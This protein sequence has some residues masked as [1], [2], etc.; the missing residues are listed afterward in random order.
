[1]A[2]LRSVV[3]WLLRL[4][5]EATLLVTTVLGG[6]LTL[7][8]AA[9]GAGVYDAVAERDG[10]AHL[11]HPVLAQMMT[12]R[13]PDTDRLL[14]VF[15][16]LGG[17]LAMT[18]IATAITA[19][20]CWRWRSWTPLIL[21]AVTVAGSLTFT[22]VG[23]AIVGRARPPLIDAV[24]PY[25]HSFS[26]PSGH[27]LNSTAIAGIVTYLVIRRLRRTVVRVLCV[28]AG[29]A[30]AAAIG[31]SR[32]FLGHHW[33]TDVLFAWLLGMAWITILITAHRVYLALHGTDRRRGVPVPAGGPDDARSARR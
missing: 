28:A 30:W 6:V 5:A 22:T 2:E 3:R 31:F 12:W 9:G 21:M 15:T 10:V 32:V 4:P 33:F 19:L 8:L 27:T 29:M 25:E 26:F 14:T 24:P 18:L 17:P 11:D 23:K 20:M 13:S 1:M 7:G 16:H